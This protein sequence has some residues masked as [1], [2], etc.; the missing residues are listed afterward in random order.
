MLKNGIF[1][2]RALALVVLTAFVLL[3][4]PVSPFA[5]APPKGGT[6]TGVVLSADMKTPVVN[7]TV[8]IRNL[9]N[10]KEYSSPTDK[11]G[12][13]KITG[14]EEG[15]YT[16]GVSSILGDY[17]LNYGVYVKTGEKAKLNLA[18]K[19]SGVLE[20]SGLGSSAPKSFFAT[21]AGILVIVAAAAGGGYAIYA[22]TK[23][24][25]ETSPVGR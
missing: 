15:W 8:K 22:L 24:P 20:G 4:T 7:A 2:S 10:Q 14:I 9:N 23:K 16:L 21:P 18:I 19:S 13:Y 25:Q 5:Q 12:M 6:L 1:R 3:L 17:N 11:T